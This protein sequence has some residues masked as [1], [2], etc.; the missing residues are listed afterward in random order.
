[1]PRAI[2]SGSISFGLV[3]IPVKLY[4]A[5][6]RKQ[7]SFHQMDARTGARV[8]MKRVSAA[9]G[10]EVP[11]EQIVKG[12]ELSPEHYVLLEP[13]E[14][15]ALD[16]EGTRTIDIEE[17]IDLADID[18]I[19]FDA[20]YYVAPVKTA[21][22]P[23]ALLVQAMEQQGKVAIARFV[24]R[25]KQYLAAL[26]AKDGAL[27]LSTMVYADEVAPVE[28]VPE[29]ASLQDVK[30]SDKELVMASQL[31]ESLSTEFE[32]SRFRDEYRDRL[33][34]LIERKAEGEPAI[35]PAEAPAATGVVD[36]MAALEASVAKAREARRRHPTASDGDAAG[37][38][39]DEA[40]PVT[41]E[42][43]ATSA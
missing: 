19:Y 24:M 1:M 2:W 40:E 16:P 35:V 14:L 6:S 25:T 23:Y 7:V 5:V 8:R 3:N 39:G 21:E 37:G 32:P 12:Y 30:V 13:A 4:N 15:D 33:L 26:R 20:A 34:E 11:Y 42:A 43:A 27:L 41:S 10:T 18:P 17:F 38:E 36:L 9:D 22:K 29:L 28:D 31:I